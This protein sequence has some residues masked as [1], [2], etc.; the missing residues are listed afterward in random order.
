[1]YDPRQASLFKLSRLR[2]P[3]YRSFLS[4][5]SLGILIGLFL[6]VLA[7]RSAQITTLELVFWF[8]SAG[9][10][11][12]ELVGFNEQGFS[13]YMMS[14]W[15]IFDLGILLLLIVYYC[16]RAYGVFVVDPHHWNQMAYD[17]L[18]AN[19]ILLLPR[20]FS[21]L[22]HYPYFSQLLIAFRLMAVD[23]AAVTV[24]VL[25]MCSGFFVFFTMSQTHSDASDVAYKIFQIIMGFTPA[26]WEL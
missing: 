19:A 14:F 23:L 20:I 6:A 3:R 12:D 7:R 1:L 21:I 9:F 16:M 22:D 2:V 4:T 8:W 25:I 15:N 26:A 18:A 24:L 17:V 5:L 10:M 11:L 13:L